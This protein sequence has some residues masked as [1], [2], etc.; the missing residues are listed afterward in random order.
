MKM[1][2]ELWGNLPQKVTIIA[3][4]FWTWLP[5][6]AF[7]PQPSCLSP[8]PAFYLVKKRQSP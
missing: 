3:L 2:D 7:W 5:F 1:L 4:A 6:C 8:L